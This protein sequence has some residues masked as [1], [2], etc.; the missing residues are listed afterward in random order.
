MS[1]RL[2]RAVAVVLS[3]V[4]VLSA[5]VAPLGFAGPASAAATGVS[6]TTASNVVVNQS[7]A[8]QTV[9]FDVT[10]ANNTT[11][12]ITVDTSTLR[13]QGATVTGA[14]AALAGGTDV[15]ISSAS[16]TGSSNVELTVEDTG[17]NNAS[18][19]A[20]V[21]VDITYDTTGASTATGLSVSVRAASGPSANRS[22]DLVPPLDSAGSVDSITAKSGQR[23]VISD[24]PVNT[25][26][27]SRAFVYV[28]VSALVNAGGS[29][30]SVSASA[31]G[32]SIGATGTQTVG[33]STVAYAEI[34][35]ANGG[36]TGVQPTVDI[37]L[38][39]VNASGV[40]ADAKLQY[41]FG[42]TVGSRDSSFVP[43]GSK[44]A[45]FVVRRPAGVTRAGPGGTGSFNTAEG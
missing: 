32:G 35:G 23:Q 27:N 10:V 26:G 8:Q 6:I 19:T 44:T 21:V 17:T 18:D 31:S 11:D 38:Q 28:D 2:I 5:V 39:S 33:G 3:V 4:T 15:S 36:L 42:A 34:T 13:G 29:I 12:T 22:A 1:N 7:S 24:I 41:A 37:T 25:G 20:S 40:A 43:D 16:V 30:G 45:S 14:S 9:A